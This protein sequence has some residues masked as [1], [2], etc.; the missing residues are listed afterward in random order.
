MGWF[1]DSPEEK[2][3]KERKKKFDK[4]LEEKGGLVNL[5]AENADLEKVKIAQNEQIISLLA[6]L[7]LI[8][9]GAISDTII[10]M[11]QDMYRRS[12][13]QYVEID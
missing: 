2:A 7:C 12:L 5:L 3:Q 9:G 6:Q 8:N 10:L 11:I 13:E 4:A 1:E